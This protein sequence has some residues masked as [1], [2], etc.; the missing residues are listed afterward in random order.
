MVAPRAGLEHPDWSPDGRTITFNVSPE[1]PTAAESGSILA[2]RPDG[3]GLRMLQHA[4]PGL[5]FFKAVWSPDGRSIL[6]GCFDVEASI[7]RICTV[8][9]GDRINIVV[10][11]PW[12][13][14]FPSWGPAD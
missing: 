14:N 5:K 6:S 10:R 12:N 13:V 8:S 2:V 4:T 9:R 1:N 3:S 7:D 11:G